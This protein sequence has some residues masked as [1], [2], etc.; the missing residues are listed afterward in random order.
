MINTYV[1]GGRVRLIAKK[2]L[3]SD[4]WLV[5]ITERTGKFI[6]EK[7]LFGVADLCAIKKNQIKLVQVTCN[8]PHTHWKMARFSEQ[9]CG[10]NVQLEQ[11]VWINRQGWVKYAYQEGDYG[12]IQ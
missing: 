11:W 12:K 8:R 4:D 6:K 1:K 9:Y 10:N 7:D 3:E 2:E 5:N